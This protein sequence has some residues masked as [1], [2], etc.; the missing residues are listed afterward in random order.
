MRTLNVLYISGSVGLG[1]DTRDMAIANELRRVCKDVEIG[2]LASGSA[3]MLLEE[4]GETLLEESDSYYDVNEAA[5]SAAKGTS[6]NLFRYGKRAAKGWLHNIALFKKIL[7]RYSFDLVVADEAYEISYYI[8]KA[9]GGRRPV[10]VEIVDFIGFEPMSGRPAERLQLWVMNRVWSGTGKTHVP[11]YHTLFVGEPD[12]VPDERFGLL[13]PRKREYAN[14][15]CTFLGYVLGFEPEDYKNRDEIK[16][17]LGYGKEPLVVC[18]SGGSPIGAE[19][20]RLCRSAYPLIRR[21]VPNLRMVLVCGPGI[22]PEGIESGEGV[23][24]KGF[25][26]NL[27]EHFAA[28]DI[29]V[30]QGGGSTTLE[31]TA[32]QRPFI[33]FP[34]EDHFEQQRLVPRG[35]CGTVRG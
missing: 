35:F 23:T 2:W 7:S 28:S 14:L 19:L 12:D 1:H 3:K 16:N 11:G 27:Y 25:V 24:V 18:S 4:R 22:S 21:R 20:L 33:Y 15:R 29:A 17:R 5:R 9:K 13:L 31:L 26:P 8:C 6:L 10:F 30:V 34:L 32:L